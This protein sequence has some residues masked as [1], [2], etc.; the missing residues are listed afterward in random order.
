MASKRNLKKK[1]AKLRERIRQRSCVGKVRFDT[2]A[3]GEYARKKIPGGKIMNCYKCD[4]CGG[5]HL[6]HGIPWW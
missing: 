2:A 4:F 3:E 5:Y 6:G 1:L